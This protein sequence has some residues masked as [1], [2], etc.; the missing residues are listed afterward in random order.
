[1]ILAP[2][3]SFFGRIKGDWLLKVGGGMGHTGFPKTF[4]LVITSE[5]GNW[6]PR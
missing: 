4:Y 3:P 1:M 6:G 5:D 2:F